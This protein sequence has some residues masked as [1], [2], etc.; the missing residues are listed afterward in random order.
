M[1]III[2]II[3]SHFKAEL[4][5]TDHGDVAAFESLDVLLEHF[6][7]NLPLGLRHPD[8]QAP[9]LERSLHLVTHTLA[10]AGI[11]RLHAHR[12]HTSDVSRRK[13]L[14][15]ARA[16][17][18][19]VN[20]HCTEFASSRHVDPI[21]GVRSSF[22]NPFS[23]GLCDLHFLS[24][25][26]ILWTTASE[27]FLAE[28]SSM[29]SSYGVVGRLTQTHQDLTNC[30][31]TLLATMRAFA[32]ASP[33]IGGLLSIQETTFHACLMNVPSRILQGPRGAGLWRSHGY[34]PSAREPP[35]E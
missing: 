35:A 7:L 27:V 9:N 5:G 3:L 11:I 20:D 4:T 8:G 21:M 29:Q 28:L 32:P 13:Y 22:L 17:V 25:L 6:V 26:Q 10:H 16:V 14:G 33:L 19:I 2:I 1:R 24:D 12:I 34:P 23:L 15:A 31:E 18:H 30:L